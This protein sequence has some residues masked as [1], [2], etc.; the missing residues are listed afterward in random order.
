M[1][2]TVLMCLLASASA[3]GAP[4]ADQA[5]TIKKVVSF[6]NAAGDP[7]LAGKIERDFEQ[8]RLDFDPAVNADG[9]GTAAWYNPQTKRISIDPYQAALV[10]AKVPG[11][12]VP[13]AAI[14]LAATLQHEYVHAGQPEA[15]H[16]SNLANDARK[17]REKETPAYDT[18]LK[19]YQGWADAVLKDLASAELWPDSPSKVA[20]LNAL[21]D[22]LQNLKDSYGDYRNG[23][24]ENR[25]S[26]KVDPNFEWTGINGAKASNPDHLDDGGRLDYG[27][28]KAKGLLAELKD[29][30][31]DIGDR[32]GAKDA[33]KRA[34]ESGKKGGPP[35]TRQKTD[36]PSDDG[37]PG[38]RS[39]VMAA[40]AGRGLPAPDALVEHLVGILERQ[41][42]GAL[43]QALQGL[44]SMQ[45]TFKGSGFTLV[46]KGFTVTG[47]F[48]ERTEY[49]LPNA[50]VVVT[51]TDGKA[52]GWVDPTAGTIEIDATFVGNAD[53]KI[54][55]VQQKLVG[56]FTGRGYEG[57]IAGQED[58]KWKVG[59]DAG[60]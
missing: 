17:T 45:G 24:R 36:K 6:L 37:D 58:S 9:S 33:K 52:S 51:E 1:M 56:A 20:R 22:T 41:G 47:T 3:A 13:F 27:V 44:T 19:G 39:R 10:T 35:A 54:E 14:A 21:E 4:T 12:G 29:Q 40:L 59:R 53:G 18:A 46:V 11:K 57:H 31:W 42:E 23:V 55:Q 60:Q 49:T 7:D 2:T 43:D 38:L 15:M 48:H 50:K 25:I 28:D 5:A 8:D 30:G 26:G 16:Q 32:K 34:D